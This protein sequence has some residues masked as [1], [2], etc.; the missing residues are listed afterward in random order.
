MMSDPLN[1]FGVFAR[2][3]SIARNVKVS[4]GECLGAGPVCQRSLML[5]V[6]G[7]ADEAEQH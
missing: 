1:A 5:E 4:L 6:G 2:T 3:N 7:M